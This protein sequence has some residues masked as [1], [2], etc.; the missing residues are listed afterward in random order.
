MVS[1]SRHVIDDG[2]I[3]LAPLER[4]GLV[5]LDLPASPRIPP[6]PPASAAE[7]DAHHAAAEP[8]K[9]SDEGADEDTEE[10]AICLGCFEE[11]DELRAL[12]CQHR[13]HRVCIDRW[14]ISRADAP[15]CP[16]CK[17]VPQLPL[18]APE[19]KPRT[20]VAAAAAAATASAAAAARS[21]RRR[22]GEILTSM[23]AS[24]WNA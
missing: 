4:H 23:S 13:F 9:R 1:S 12:S 20:A 15:S 11:H 2:G 24:A 17:T 5:W 3:E 16:L 18:S 7:P 19:P 8:G 6:H 14:L 22:G 10:C 21:A